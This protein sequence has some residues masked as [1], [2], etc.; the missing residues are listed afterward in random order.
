MLYKHTK[1]KIQ[2]HA[3]LRFKKRLKDKKRNV[4]AAIISTLSDVLI[5]A[6][7]DLIFVGN[8]KKRITLRLRS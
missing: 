7:T 8:K 4:Y 1:R 2:A 3:V 5:K 6:Q